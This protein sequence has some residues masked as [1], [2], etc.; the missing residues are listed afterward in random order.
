[1]KMHLYV[2]MLMSMHLPTHVCGYAQ[3]HVVAKNKT[4]KL[5]GLV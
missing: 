4:S 5:H 2:F 1:M 3:K